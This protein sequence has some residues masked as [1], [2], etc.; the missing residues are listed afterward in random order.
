MDVSTSCCAPYVTLRGDCGVQLTAKEAV[1]YGAIRADRYCTPRLALP[2]SD[3]I[4][5]SG[6]GMITE[7]SFSTIE[8][9]ST[10]VSQNPHRLCLGYAQRISG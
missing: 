6:T 3:S 1:G 8:Y 2:V 5:H 10:D 7:N 4:F 9:E